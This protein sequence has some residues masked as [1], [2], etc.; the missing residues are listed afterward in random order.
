MLVSHRIHTPPLA[1]VH[2]ELHRA[3]APE[4]V[5]RS[6]LLQGVVQD[7]RITVPPVRADRSRLMFLLQGE[8]WEFGDG[9]TL[10]A[11]QGEVVFIPRLGDVRG[12]SATTLVLEI[13][14]EGSGASSAPRVIKL[15]AD[16]LAAAQELAE[17]LPHPAGDRRDRRQVDRLC[18]TASRALRV[19][20]HAGLPLR[21][22]AISSL[23]VTPTDDEQELWNAMDQSL[24]R[25]D[26]RPDL[27]D[28]ESRLVCSRRTLHRRIGALAAKYRMYDGVDDWRGQRDFYRQLIAVLFLSH[29]D[30]SPRLV[31]DLV[32]YRSVA[33]MCHAFQRAGLPAPGQIAQ[34]LAELAPVS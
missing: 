13:D 14:S 32:G 28:L 10:H 29:P 7:E 27:T 23:G 1:G 5:M 6:V 8:S 33:A 26:Q 21:S 30:A 20:S 22:E 34:R 16:C 24:E 19:F 17:A 4:L 9:F 2:L 11:H 18:E 15:D 12:R 31:S 25:L 3:I